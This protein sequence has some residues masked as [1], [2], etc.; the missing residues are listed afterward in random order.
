M[1]ILLLET[2]V[3]PIKLVLPRSPVLVYIFNDMSCVLSKQLQLLYVQ[4]KSLIVYT[5][6]KN[7]QIKV[8]ICDAGL[9]PYKVFN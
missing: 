5:N 6:I 3:P 4:Q 1:R 7:L 8:L 2:L 9:L